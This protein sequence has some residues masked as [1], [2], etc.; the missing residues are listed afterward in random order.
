MS[1]DCYSPGSGTTTGCTLDA[2]SMAWSCLGECESGTRTCAAGVWGS[3][4]G[5][6]TPAVEICNTLDD[7]C[8]GQTDEATDIPGLNQPCGNALG[9]CTPGI[10]LCVNGVEICDGGDG[11]Y[12]GECNLQD[13]DCD[14]EV[15]EPDEVMDGSGLPCGDTEGAC[16]AGHTECIGGT[17]QC[18]DEVLP[19][20]EVCD[21]VDNDCDGVI[22]NGDLC[23][24]LWHCVEV[25]SQLTECRPECL[26]GEFPC[27][28]GDICEQVDVDGTLMEICMPDLGSCDPPCPAGEECQDGTCVDPCAGVSCEVWEECVGGA[29]VD[30]SCT[31]P[32]ISCPPGQYCVD[33]Q[34]Q[35]DPCTNAD[36][37]VEEYCVQTSCDAS[38][39]CD[40]ASCEPLCY[41]QD[42]ELCDAEAEEG[43]V[44]DLCADT[45]CG[46]GQRCNQTTGL[47][48]DDPCA[49]VGPFCA[50]NEV[51]LEGECIEHP[52][53]RIDRPPFFDCVIQEGTDELG[54]PVAEPICRADTAYYEEGTSGEDYLAT[55]GGGCACRTS[56]EGA[57][58]GVLVLLLA[59]W[60]GV[61]RRRRRS[62][63]E[64]V[65]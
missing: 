27:D 11:P 33:H 14:G 46:L 53:L 65:L 3:C 5:E 30:T 40:E 38:G 63:E 24:E 43:C 23:D 7:D 48:E 34:C 57:G 44:E 50:P 20:E 8:D 42:G 41:C 26:S 1:G 6:T 56:G 13:D 21:G 2:S 31:G 52:C 49:A 19:S 59:L 62:S 60:F 15:D 4:L 18:M 22:D 9:R 61:R 16:E 28:P 64:E 29:C 51:C 45:Q 39:I 25:N 54:D 37:D 36:C 58:T 35:A 32:G 17:W 47:C 12:P 10:M 55:G